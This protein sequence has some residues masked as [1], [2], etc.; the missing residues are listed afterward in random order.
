MPGDGFR[1]MFRADNVLLLPEMAVYS[2][3]ALLDW[4]ASSCKTAGARGA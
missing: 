1:A 2:E 4:Y 3:I